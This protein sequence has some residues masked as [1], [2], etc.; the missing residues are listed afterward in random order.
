MVFTGVWPFWYRVRNASKAVKN[1]IFL[2]QNFFFLPFPIHP[3]SWF[4]LCVCDSS[5][6]LPYNPFIRKKTSYLRARFVTFLE[7][8]FCRFDNYLLLQK[9]NYFG[10]KSD[11]IVEKKRYGQKMP[12]NVRDPFSPRGLPEK[13]IMRLYHIVIL[14][15]KFVGLKVHVHEKDL[16]NMNANE[17]EKKIF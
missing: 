9:M 6:C 15:W 2:H 17:K 1:Y 7:W 10:A 4:S 16:Q 11:L 14:Y 5:G 8:T 3:F 12:Q 13:T